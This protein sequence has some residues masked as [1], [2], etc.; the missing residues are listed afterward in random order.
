MRNHPAFQ[1]WEDAFEF[2][3]AE[4]IRA[5]EAAES[6]DLIG[7]EILNEYALMANTIARQMFED[8]RT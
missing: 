6:G 8:A 1:S 2:A 5:C 3:S 4:G 7:A